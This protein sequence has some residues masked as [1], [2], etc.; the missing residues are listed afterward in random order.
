MEKVAFL[1][2]GQGAQFVGMAKNFYDEHI[3]ARQT[4]EEANDV[5]GF[6]LAQLCFEGTLSTLTKTENAQVAI[7]TASVVAYRVYMEHI[8]FAPQF[9]AGH[10]LGEYS[11]LT[12]VGALKF[13]DA[14]RIVRKR[15]ELVQEVVDKD[16]GGMTIIDGITQEV[17]EEECGKALS[18]ERFVWINCYNSPMQFAISGNK[19]TVETVESALLDRGANVTP[20]FGS[21]PYHSPLIAYAVPELRAA[22][23]SCRLY[24]FKWPIIANVTGRPYKDS[25]MVPDVMARHMTQPVKWIDT[26]QCL[27]RFG[28]TVAIEMGPKNV[29]TNLVKANTPEIEAYCYGQKE[30]RRNLVELLGSSDTPRKDSATVVTRCLA[31]AAATPNKNFNNDEYVAGVVENYRKIQS[32][33]DELDATK[34]R[35][36]KDQMNKA[37]DIL[38]EIFRTKQVDAAEQEDWIHQIIDETGNFYEL[39][40]RQTSLVNL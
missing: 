38:M 9:C 32:I 26:M 35:P 20:L 29:L 3:I 31:A 28:V 2:T 7:L 40:E 25:G 6:D 19:E 11:A 36:S 4:F 27:K 17:V 21:A 33:Q 15:G 5:L 23:D 10:S 39:S 34:S 22:F 12:C 16:I 24:S 1:F 18:N 8:G 13:S 30:D 14:L 37:L